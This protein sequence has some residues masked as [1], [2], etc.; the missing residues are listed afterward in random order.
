MV[1]ILPSSPPT[2]NSDTKYFSSFVLS[3]SIHL[4]IYIIINKI[5]LTDKTNLK[6]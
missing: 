6:L 4:L 5:E 2:E 3:T 1:I